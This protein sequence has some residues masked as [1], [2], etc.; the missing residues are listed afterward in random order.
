MIDEK[1]LHERIEDE[2]TAVDVDDY[3]MW[4]DGI[5]DEVNVGVTI[6][7]SRVLKECDPIAYN[8]GKADWESAED[9]YELDGEYYHRSEVDDIIEEMENEEG[10]RRWVK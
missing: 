1:R 3:D 6:P 9:F 4:L 7:A 5:Y 10:G 2:L 8:C